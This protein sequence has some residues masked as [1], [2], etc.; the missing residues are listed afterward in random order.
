MDMT[1]A[2]KVNPGP[3][4]NDKTVLERYLPKE[5]GTRWVPLLKYKWGNLELQ[6]DHAF[7]IM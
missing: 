4:F 7:S 1:P 2:L 6:N 3:D 5:V